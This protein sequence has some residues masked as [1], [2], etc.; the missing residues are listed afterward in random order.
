MNLFI[1]KIDKIKLILKKFFL[2]NLYYNLKSLNINFSDLKNKL[3]AI[4]NNPTNIFYIINYLT[5]I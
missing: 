4:L 1:F 2:N 3:L 5:F